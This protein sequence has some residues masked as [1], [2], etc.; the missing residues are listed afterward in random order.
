MPGY[1]LLHLSMYMH[2]FPYFKL[3]IKSIYIIEKL[4]FIHPVKNEPIKYSKVKGLP[5]KNCL[6]V[7]ILQCVSP[8]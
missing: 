2:S 8:N 3:L 6:L 5:S 4:A 7:L 1:F